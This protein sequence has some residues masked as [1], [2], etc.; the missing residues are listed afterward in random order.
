MSWW[1]S[2]LKQIGL[3]ALQMAGEELGKKATKKK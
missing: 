1:K 3:Y 2:V